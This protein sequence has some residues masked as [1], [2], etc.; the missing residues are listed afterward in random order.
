MREEDLVCR[1]CGKQVKQS[2]TE[3]PC[4]RLAGW[5]M[6]TEWGGPG[7]VDSCFLCC[8]D[9]LRAWAESRSPGIPDAFLK[10]FND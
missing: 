8:S 9:C 3:R 6:V 4:E 2:E 5:F 10:A 1:S 7:T